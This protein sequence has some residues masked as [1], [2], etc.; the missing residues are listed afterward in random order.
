M[1]SLKLL[2]LGPPRIEREGVPVDVTR[3]K[4]I[5]LLAYLAVTGESQRRDTL[6]TLLWPDADQ[7]RARAALRRDLSVLNKALGEG[8]LVV[9]RET[10]NL[11]RTA[12]VWLDV[13][14]F[15]DSLA[16]CETH[17]HSPDY[18]CPACLSPLT[19]AVTLYRD[20]FL[21][22]FTLRDSPDFDEWQFFQAEGLRQEL[23]SAL[24][25][26][27]RGY[28]GQG[29]Y[30]S[31]I[32]Y[33][34]RWLALDP[35]HEPAHQFLMQLYAWVG[36]H[37]AALRQY[38]ECAR[39]LEEE[40]G[41]PPSE[42]TT[43][44]CEAI[45]ERRTLP[46][47]GLHAGPLATEA[48]T[49]FVPPPHLSIR[50]PPFLETEEEPAEA[51]P[52]VFVAR[53]RE[54]SRL[55][56][57][58]DLVLDGQGQVAFVTGEAGSGKTALLHEFARRA[59]D[60]SADLVVAIGNCSAHTGIG[61]PY[62]PFREVLSVLS[63]DVEARVG[64]GV[65][66]RENAHR[67]WACVPVLVQ[68]LIDRGPDLVDS[69]VP[70]AVLVSRAAAFARGAAGW[71]DRLAELT[72]RKAARAESTDLEQSRIFKQ[73]TDVLQALARQ[74]PLLLLLD[75]LQWADAASIS[76]L[77]HLGRRLSTS[78]ILIVG[79]YRPEDV[80]LGRPSTP[81]QAREGPRGVASSGQRERHPLESVLNELKRDFGDVWVDL[82]QAAAIEGRQFVDALLDTEPNR[83][84][85]AFRQ[86]LFRHT[87]GHPLF[88]IELLRDM[89]ERRDLVQDEEGQ[90]TVGPTLD[91]SAVPARVEGVIEERLDRLEP[92]LRELL[93]VAAV[94]GE[95]FT[96]Q[97]LA[98]LQSVEE[99]EIVRQLVDSL[100][101]RH[102]LVSEK[103]VKSLNGHRLYRF[104]FR[105]TLFQQYL[106]GCLSPVKRELLHADVARALEKL[107]AGHTDEIAVQLTRH[108][109]AAGEEERAIPY[110]LKAGDQARALYAHAQ[111][112]RYYQQ[113][114][115]VLL[116]H[117]QEE[118]AARTLLKLGLVYTAAFKPEE[119]QD[120]YDQAFTLWE[121]L[122]KASDLPDRSTPPPVVLHLALEE[123][124]ILDPGRI[125]DDVSTFVAVQLFEGLVRVGPDYSVLPAVAAR[126]EVTDRGTT[127]IF[128]LREG[129]CWSDGMPVTA[130]D[131][132]YTW[133]RNL[134]PATRSPVAHLLY[135]IQNARAFGEGEIDDPAEVGVIAADDLTLEVRLEQPTAY[136]P[137]LLTHTISYPV[138]RWAVEDRAQ[139]WAYPGNLVSNGPY[140]LVEWER[141][142]RLV[143]RRN[144]WYRGRFPG[145]ATQVNCTVITEFGPALDLY[146]AGAVDGMTMFN[147]DPGTVARVRADHGRDLVSIPRPSTFYLVFRTDRPPFDDVRVRQAF[148]HAVDREELTRVAFQGERL[149]ATGGFVPPDIPGHSPGLGLA[150]DPDR[151]RRLLA[152]AG[153]LGGQ[154][155]P[156]VTWFCSGGSSSERVVP[157]LARAWRKNLGLALEARSL[158]WGAFI[159]QIERDPA[160]LTLI[161]WSAGIP[162]PDDFLRVVFHS[163]EGLNYP[164][165]HNA[166]FDA[167]VEEAA[168]VTDHA[169]RMTL[170]QE[171]DRVLVAE[172]SVIMPL[173]YGRGR[174]LVKPWVSLPPISSVS[175]C[176]KN[177]VVEREGR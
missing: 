73:Y 75:D 28:S 31:A 64:G 54:L 117:G 171:A 148:M 165:W 85:E 61:D 52:G 29:E 127:Y 16:A 37:A 58:L 33:A 27:A 83:L 84:G 102:H 113:A 34:R 15:Y 137:H 35:L 94:E 43:E 68:T 59:Q 26:L 149:P 134:D 169:R 3:R 22:G 164:R 135:P 25:R 6:A 142:E 9:D 131:F 63:G 65:L 128:H 47:V 72:A 10:V 53:E 101:R 163:T 92:D 81:R 139:D 66:N 56:T 80:A 109:L 147:A 55:G 154:D 118:L 2:L 116:E 160:H 167:L 129:L 13:D 44:L 98:R 173:S 57:F 50:P 36:Q 153:Y 18:V 112:E 1:S 126:W 5:A 90:W 91:W 168:R 82:N 17:G 172:E 97:V 141:G 30:E 39:V 152:Q 93:S 42:K 103:G 87:R 136:F 71:S 19:E 14:H 132:E 151:A 8:W 69:F 120:A 159:K 124:L 23:A 138:P 40:L 162:D 155:F 20:D 95:H 49:L 170:Y 175:V 32:P 79:A 41:L 157:F 74:R 115:R 77:F 174:M 60:V 156:E 123:P 11:N 100:E 67:L 86:A 111:A 106:Y 89:R 121:P 45:K 144:R 24:E 158:E 12:N 176:L 48:R 161:G 130:R 114:V 88:T 177:I 99:R 51:E 108:W 150:Y 38:R 133:R 46:P 78:R 76:L 7:S 4:A 107:Y 145:N 21:A 62:L 119:A 140:E 166:R 146:A 96:A 70:S 104:R 143:L 105:H 122:R 125:D 110:L